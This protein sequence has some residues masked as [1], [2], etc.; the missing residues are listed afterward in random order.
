MANQGLLGLNRFVCS[1]NVCPITH[2]RIRNTNSFISVGTPPICYNLAAIKGYIYRLVRRGFRLGNANFVFPNRNPILPQD[3]VTLAM[4]PDEF[5]TIQQEWRDSDEGMR[6][7]EQAFAEHRALLQGYDEGTGFSDASDESVPG[8][9]IV[10]TQTRWGILIGP[11][12]T[13]TIP[14]QEILNVDKYLLRPDNF[15]DGTIQPDDYV[16]NNRKR[17]LAFNEYEYVATARNPPPD[18]MRNLQIFIPGRTDYEQY[19][20]YDTL[21]EYVASMNDQGYN[22]SIADVQ[23]TLFP[24]RGGTKRKNKRTRKKKRTIVKKSFRR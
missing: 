16:F 18:V 3:L 20:P 6:E 23:G 19:G 10:N 9:H 12:P 4:N 14:D 5:D 7:R 21:G 1:D 17:P 22:L 11:S 2:E 24:R 8:H 13:Q 15:V